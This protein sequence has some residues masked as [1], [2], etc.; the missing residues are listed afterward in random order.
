MGSMPALVS[1]DLQ[2][3]DHSQTTCSG[4]VVWTCIVEINEWMASNDLNFESDQ[5]GA[6]L[7]Q[8]SSAIEALSSQ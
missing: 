8:L 4:M 6:Y 3:Y 1:D 5:D 2:I 7:A